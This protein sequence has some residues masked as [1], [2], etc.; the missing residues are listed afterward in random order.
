MS[1][2]TFYG[3]AASVITRTGIGPDDLGLADNTALTT[4]LGGVLG[5]LTDQFDRYMR[6]TYIGVVD[7]S[8]NPVPVPAGLNGIANDAAADRVIQ[9]IASRQAP[10]VRIDDFRVST[11]ST[12]VLTADVKDRLKL[13]AKGRGAV[14]VDLGQDMIRDLPIIF[15]A[16][17]LDGDPAD[18]P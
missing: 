11:T 7:I 10:V 15:T 6:T 12:V 9:Q 4:Y 5:E 18:L 17:Q 2:Q 1:A 8:N 13:Y 16:D 14:S 3:D